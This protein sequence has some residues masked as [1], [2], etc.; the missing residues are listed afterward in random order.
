MPEQSTNGASP[1]NETP[2]LIN[3]EE[4]ATMLGVSERTLWRLLSADKLP[5]PL[6]LGG[7]TRW[8]LEEVR[9]WVDSGC[10]PSTSSSLK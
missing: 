5:Q 3:A 9:R 7:S 8:R 4:F 1:K 6:R 2:L 10:Q